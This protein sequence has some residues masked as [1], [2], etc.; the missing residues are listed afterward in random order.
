VEKGEKDS[1]FEVE[2][3]DKLHPSQLLKGVSHD[4]MCPCNHVLTRLFALS[5]SY[6]EFIPLVEPRDKCQANPM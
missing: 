6:Q 3:L 4:V 5:S 1:K 2:K